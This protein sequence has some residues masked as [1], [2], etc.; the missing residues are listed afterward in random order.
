LED[1]SYDILNDVYTIA[2]ILFETPEEPNE[3][4]FYSMPNL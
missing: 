4:L 2:R 1:S 3:V